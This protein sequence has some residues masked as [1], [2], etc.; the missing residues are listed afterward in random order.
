M[1]GNQFPLK[2]WKY[3]LSHYI[4]VHGMVPYVESGLSPYEQIYENIPNAGSLKSFGCQVY[5]I[6][7]GRIRER[8][9]NNVKR[10]IF[11]GYIATS[12]QMY[13]WYMYTK[14]VKTYKHGRFD[15]VMNDLEIP[16]PNTRKL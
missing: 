10:G 14:L 11:T 3:S 7:P 4:T 12:S 1:E 13:Y 16:T 5:I 9:D 15:E 6:P 2:L 8:M